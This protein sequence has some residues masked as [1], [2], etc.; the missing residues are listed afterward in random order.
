MD[1]FQQILDLVRNAPTLD[2]WLKMARD[3]TIL[4]GKRGKDVSLVRPAGY[5]YLFEKSLHSD[6][7]A[8]SS[9]DED[10]ISHQS[11]IEIGSDGLSGMATSAS[12]EEQEHVTTLGSFAQFGSMS[13][14]PCT[15][16][17]SVAMLVGLIKQEE[18]TSWDEDIDDKN[19]FIFG[20]TLRQITDNAFLQEGHHVEIMHILQKLVRNL[21]RPEAAK[22]SSYLR[23]GEFSPRICYVKDPV[24]SIN[25]KSNAGNGSHMRQ[26]GDQLNLGREPQLEGINDCDEL[27]QQILS[28][29]RIYALAQTFN[30]T[31]LMEAIVI[32]LQVAWNAYP[33]LS[34]LLPLLDVA[35][36]ISSK[37]PFKRAKHPFRNWIVG[38]IADVW[39]LFQYGCPARLWEVMKAHPDLY[40]AIS[41]ERKEMILRDDKAKYV[42]IQALL[43]S[44]GII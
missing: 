26:I 43:Q 35:V 29:G 9:D 14:F 19:D 6:N 42:D 10:R 3:E 30:M 13:S 34:Q 25:G 22:I 44:R 7:H 40:T 24:I 12:H 23:S 18:E 38:F 41:E 2:F 17:P 37:E 4:K 16:M 39:D 1:L 31:P 27:K 21:K 15:N 8:F 32:K 33:G 28:L 20:M 5:P 11:S 36:M